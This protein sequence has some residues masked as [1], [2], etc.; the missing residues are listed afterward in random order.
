MV[1]DYSRNDSF[2]FASVMSEQRG[3]VEFIKDYSLSIVAIPAQ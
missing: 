1:T 2:T 3:R